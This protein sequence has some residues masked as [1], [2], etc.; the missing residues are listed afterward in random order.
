MNNW[1]QE[2]EIQLKQGSQCGLLNGHTGNSPAFRTSRFMS[3]WGEPG[4]SSK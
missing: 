1:R 4:R 2:P 3:Q